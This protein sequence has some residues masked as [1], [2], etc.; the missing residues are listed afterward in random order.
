MLNEFKVWCETIDEA[1]N[2]LRCLAKLGIKWNSG[3]EILDQDVTTK[4]FLD[5]SFCVP[6]GLEI[7]LLGNQALTYNKYKDSFN[8]HSELEEIP[9]NVLLSYGR[10]QIG[11]VD[12]LLSL[13]SDAVN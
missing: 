13:V 2:A 9:I 11:S 12:K 7:G 8:R 4:D 6:C 10:V 5:G 1:K 3:D